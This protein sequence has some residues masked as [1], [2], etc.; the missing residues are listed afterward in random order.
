MILSISEMVGSSQ[1][2]FLAKNHK[3]WS[4]KTGIRV[5]VGGSI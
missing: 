2:W 5:S 4:K 3:G 1:A